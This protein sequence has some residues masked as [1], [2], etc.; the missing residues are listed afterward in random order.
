MQ[1]LRDDGELPGVVS[2][3]ALFADYWS[4]RDPYRP[5]RRCHTK[6]CSCT[7]S[8]EPGTAAPARPG[9]R[10]GA[11]RRAAGPAR[12]AG[13][14]PPCAARRAAAGRRAGPGPAPARTRSGGP[15]TSRCRRG[16]RARAGPAP[17]G[18]HGLPG[19]RWRTPRGAPAIRATAGPERGGAYWARRLPAAPAARPAPG[20]CTGRCVRGRGAALAVGRGSPGSPRPAAGPAASCW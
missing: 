16:A 18:A 4:E 9:R 5:D 7:G 14:A 15:A 10:S 20:R 8:S 13:R 6:R 3:A 11:G 2:G 1:R 19:C 12:T 17:P